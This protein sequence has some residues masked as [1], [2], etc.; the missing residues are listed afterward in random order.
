M[1]RDQPLDCAGSY[2]LEE[3]GIQLF[4]S[5]EGDDYTAIIGLPLTR[6]MSMLIRAGFT[7]S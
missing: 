7:T 4:E 1:Q 5:M 3:G 6:V 2:K